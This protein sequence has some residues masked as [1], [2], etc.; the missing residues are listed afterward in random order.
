MHP[1]E[2][3]VLEDPEAD[4]VIAFTIAMAPALRG[5]PDVPVLEVP[6]ERLVLQALRVLPVLRVVSR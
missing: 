6:L 2:Q 4:R 1:E 5:F 3:G